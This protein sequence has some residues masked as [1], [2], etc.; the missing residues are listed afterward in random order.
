MRRSLLKGVI[1]EGMFPDER[2][3]LITDQHGNKVSTIVQETDVT[4]IRD[5]RGTV[6]VRVVGEQG[7][8]TL[9]MLPGEV[10]GTSRVLAVRKADLQQT[11]GS[12]NGNGFH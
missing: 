2:V 8:V 11:N 12:A 9:V 1:S 5:N 3:F 7:D 4:N 6:E 10:L